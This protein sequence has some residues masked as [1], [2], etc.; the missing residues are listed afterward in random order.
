MTDPIIE[1]LDRII[2]LLSSLVKEKAARRSKAASVA[3]THYLGGDSLADRLVTFLSACP[4][5]AYTPREICKHFPK[6]KGASVRTILSGLYRQGVIDKRD[7]HHFT[8]QKRKD[9]A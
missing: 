5:A 7:Y 9:T 4:A 8:A 3:R 1:H 6:D 2:A